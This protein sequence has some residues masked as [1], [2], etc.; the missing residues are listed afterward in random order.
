MYCVQIGLARSWRPCHR[1]AVPHLRDVIHCPRDVHRTRFVAVR[2]GLLLLPKG[3]SAA[4]CT[5][6]P[7][8]ARQ[9][10]DVRDLLMADKTW[11]HGSDVCG[12]R[13]RAAKLAVR[14]ASDEHA[15]VLQAQGSARRLLLQH[16]E[17]RK[18]KNKKQH[19]RTSSQTSRRGLGR[20][21]PSSPPPPPPPPPRFTTAAVTAA[22]LAT[23]ADVR[24]V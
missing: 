7:V 1:I 11:V 24:T 12:A 22:A 14:L 21:S 16:Q 6:A 5:F 23:T 2:R 15:R 8:S 18:I 10:D 13:R 3:R 20:S 9:D 4:G 17:T 19:S